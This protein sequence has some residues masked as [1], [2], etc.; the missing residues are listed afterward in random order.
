LL[1]INSLVH[2]GYRYNHKR[3]TNLLMF[4]NGISIHPNSNSVEE[5]PLGETEP[6]VEVEVGYHRVSW[7]SFRDINKH[8]KL[9]TNTTLPLKSG[10][11]GRVYD[12]L[13]DSR[14]LKVVLLCVENTNC[15]TACSGVN[16]K[17]FRAEITYA[18]FASS[19]GV[20]PSVHRTFVVFH[21][22]DVTPNWGGIV[23][24]KYELTLDCYIR[25]HEAQ[26][27]WVD[28]VTVCMH[29]MAMRGILLLD[30][31]STNIVVRGDGSNAM[32][33]DYNN[34]YC[35]PNLITPQH[36]INEEMVV[37]IAIEIVMCMLL[38]NFIRDWVKVD[39]WPL[40]S[41]V[42]TRCSA[43]SSSWR[44]AYDILMVRDKD[45]CAI[46][47]A[48][49]LKDDHSLPTTPWSFLMSMHTRIYKR[50]LV[51]DPTPIYD[52][53]Y[54]PAGECRLEKTVYNTCQY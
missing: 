6:E 3:E 5:I 38:Y 1:C 51:F 21:Q 40:L 33:I 26:F 2:P 25:S 44:T 27:D 7:P 8:V 14:V 15:P 11:T 43:N 36:T 30:M 31:K 23:M 19:A 10:T 42:K 29:V 34:S 9:C 32:L 28:R 47:C 4:T 20:G 16:Y 45:A 12:V 50:P 37:I 49:Q 17:D 24:D 53:R 39:V 35:V 13:N 41:H 48:Y 54:Q 18:R 22:D 52:K 46:L